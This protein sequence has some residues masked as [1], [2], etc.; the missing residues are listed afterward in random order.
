M[1]QELIDTYR[2]L[3]T[4]LQNL[5][6]EIAAA[7][8]DLGLAKMKQ[9]DTKRRMDDIEMMLA[10][11][12]EG[13]ND[14][15]RKAALADALKGHRAYQDTLGLYRADS[16]EVAALNI[17]ADKLN[18]RFAAVGY[19]ARLHAALLTW[20]GSAGVPVNLDKLGD[21]MFQAPPVKGAEHN[22]PYVNGNTVTADDAAAM[23]L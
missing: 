14:T 12:V 3:M 4:S 16:A 6:D 2:R 9:A 22:P 20:L 1:N 7:Q 17:E 15:K 21:V 18:A 13:S 19:Q 5:P 8:T 23:G 10:G 11:T